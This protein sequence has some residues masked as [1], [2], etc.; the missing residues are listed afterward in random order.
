MPHDTLNTS[1]AAVG[2]TGLD[3]LQLLPAANYSFGLIVLGV[4]VMVALNHFAWRYT[5]GY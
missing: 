4:I 5:S 3:N 1:I 2:N